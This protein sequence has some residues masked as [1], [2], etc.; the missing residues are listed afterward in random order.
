MALNVKSLGVRFLSY[1]LLSNLRSL[2]YKPYSNR[3]KCLMKN[4]QKLK[5]K[6]LKRMN[7]NALNP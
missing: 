5:R 2:T 1:S 4:P 7:K 3:Y 6:K